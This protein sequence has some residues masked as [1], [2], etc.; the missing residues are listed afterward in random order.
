[1]AYVYDILLNFNKDLI[2]FFEWEDIDNIKYAKKITLFKIDKKTMNDFLN[3]EVELSFDFIK[4]TLRYELD[5]LNDKISYTLFTDG[6]IVLGVS[7]RN[8]KIDLLSRLIIDEE[9]EII[10]ISE[11][12]DFFSIDYKILKERKR[13]SSLLTRKETKI[14]NDLKNEITKLFEEKNKEKL[15][16][17]Y[18]EFTNKESNNLN[19]IYNFLIKSLDNITESH[20]KIF[21][22]LKLSR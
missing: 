20:L 3:Y 7:I 9:D 4:D 12:L 1:M 14:K 2:E 19:Y 18:Y 15:E 21:E 6:E 13:E 17:L 22:I 10:N 5:G 8:S 16:Y 11:G